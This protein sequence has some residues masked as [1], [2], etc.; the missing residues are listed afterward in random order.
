[1]K[2]RIVETARIFK[3]RLLQTPLLLGW[4]VV[5]PLVALYKDGWM[6]L[7]FGLVNLALVGVYAALIR[8][9]TPDSLRPHPVKRPVP[10]L[11]LALGLFV[12]FLLIQILD[13]GVWNIQPWQGG[14]RSFFQGI[15]QWVYSL[16]V[17]PMWAKQDTYLALSS[18]LK[19][20]LPTVFVFL[21]LGYGGRA[22]GL[23]NPHWKL[24]TLL[25][26]ITAAFGGLTGI[27]T[28]A[29]L[30]QVIAL[31]GIGI[32]VNALPEELFFRGM[33]L[34]R[35]EKV[36]ANPLNA[37]VVSALLFNAL[38]LPI[39]LRNGVSLPLAV[40]DIFSIGYPSGLIWG[41]LYL[42][43]RSILPGVF[44]HAANLNL[45]FIMMSL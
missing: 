26:G 4:L 32:L 24:T 38:H 33:L 3:I 28:R 7:V 21:A 14:V 37:L 43:T 9:M 25:V 41:Y 5:G 44:W 18:T 30:A 13:F 12:L 10:E 17:L 31:Y 23:A 27:L 15:G 11:M 40:L 39:V 35:L 20:L 45:G 22:M 42:R 8:W 2:N 6:G 36:F 1:M 16:E 34:P 29:P 19:Q